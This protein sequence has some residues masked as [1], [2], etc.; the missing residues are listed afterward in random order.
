MAR[1]IQSLLPQ[2]SLVHASGDALTGDN[3]EPTSTYSV[4]TYSV[5]VPDTSLVIPAT[6]RRTLMARQYSVKHH[7]L[8]HAHNL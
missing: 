2:L 3:P 5:V 8:T 6:E 1:H 4:G 7:K